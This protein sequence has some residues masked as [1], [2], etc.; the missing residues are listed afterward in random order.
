MDRIALSNGIILR[1]FTEADVNQLLEVKNNKEAVV[2]LVQDNAG[3]TKEDIRNWII[4]H[5][6]N[7]KNLILAIE[8]SVGKKIIGH[9]GLYDIN[10]DTG[11]CT[12][13]ILIGLPAYWHRGI[14]REATLA[15]LSIAFRTP[16]IHC[17]QLHV[18]HNHS[19]AI[20]LYRKL[21]FERIKLLEAFTTK[22]GVPTDVLVMELHQLH[23]NDP[24]LQAI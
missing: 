18:L 12:F 15:M 19:H 20:E 7:E 6:H 24:T 17:V 10:P 22:A 16:G 14:G 11:I 2:W 4:F 9:V 21:G 13:G 23:D 1:P 8:D 3:Y 5:N